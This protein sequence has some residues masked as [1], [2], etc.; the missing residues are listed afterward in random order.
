V[1]KN[2]AKGAFTSV[3][4]L[5]VL[6]IIFCSI[7]ILQVKKD[8]NSNI[9]I[10][11]DAIWWAYVTIT[12]VGYGDKYPGTDRRAVDPALLMTADVR[13]FR[14]FTAYVASWFVEPVEK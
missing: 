8:P 6:L 5:A 14:T 13:L 4:I 12:T 1:F 10:A 3:S 9:K 11:E 2:E 7:G